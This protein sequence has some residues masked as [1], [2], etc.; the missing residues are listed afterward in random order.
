MGYRGTCPLDLGHIEKFGNF[1]ER[2]ISVTESPTVTGEHLAEVLLSSLKRLHLDTRKLCAQTYDGA[3]ATSGKVS[4]EFRQSSS[5]QLHKHST[6]S[7]DHTAAIW[8]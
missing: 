7:A 8:S 3:A 4:R 5:R 1:N 2:L 6:T